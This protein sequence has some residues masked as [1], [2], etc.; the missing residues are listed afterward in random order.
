MG[1]ED[2]DGGRGSE[3]DRKFDFLRKEQYSFYSTQQNAMVCFTPLSLVLPFS[4]TNA[5]FYI[6]VKQEMDNLKTVLRHV[7]TVARPISLNFLCFTTYVEWELS[8]CVDST[9]NRY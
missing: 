3:G 9:W 5:L 7:G 2:D 6:L 1:K 8:V 4:F